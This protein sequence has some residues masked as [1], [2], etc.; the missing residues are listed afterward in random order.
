MLRELPPTAGLPIVPG[1]FFAQSRQLDEELSRFL[2]VSWVQIECSGSAALVVALACLKSLSKRNSVVIPAF[3]CPLVALAVA[4]AGLRAKL[5]D[6]GVDSFDFDM[7]KLEVLVDDD[8][9]CVIPTH[10]GGL[11]ADVGGV[12]AVARAAGAY[13]L[14][15]AAQA[16]GASFRGKP[17][18]TTGD[19]GMFSLTRGKGLTIYEGGFL[20]AGSG[21]LQAALSLS[22][23][24]L[25]SGSPGIEF[26]RFLELLG[27]CFLYNP[28]G[29]SFVY[30]MPLRH[31][32]RQGYFIEA[33]G[34]DFPHNIP[35]HRVGSQRKSVG[36]SALARLPS[37]LSGNRQRAL[38]RTAVLG[39]IPG[40]KVLG[41]RE[42]CLGAW[43]FIMVLF[44]SEE[45]CL[46]ALKQ[47]WGSGLGVTK[48]FMHELGG[49]DYLANIVEGDPCPN[50]ASF[51]RRCLT[52]S[53]S[54]WVDD[55]DF[56]RVARTIEKSIG[57]RAD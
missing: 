42:H 25:T 29:L 35:L 17:V 53:N 2:G 12:L 22:S 31:R 5:C 23:A 44:D 36:A 15:D 52:I 10:T 9:L 51:A 45:C 24:R 26:L 33:V 1:D 49:Y 13:V 6:V 43:P 50:A 7:E 16:L 41:E 30:G 39:Q 21:E 14:E 37:A 48:L 54:A 3:T 38:E 27:Y 28:I 34:E 32:L 19:I 46:R 20:T 8:T 18:G 47:L 56:A 40:I 55:D 57:R 4:Q 11:P